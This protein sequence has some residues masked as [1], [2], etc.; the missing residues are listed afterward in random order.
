MTEKPR[1]TLRKNSDETKV[2]GSFSGI[3]SRLK[4]EKNQFR[5]KFLFVGYLFDRLSKLGAT[6]YLVGGEAVEYLAAGQFS[7]GDIDITTSNRAA[8]IKLLRSLGFTKTGM[9]WLNSDLKIAVQIV[10]SYPSSVEKARTISID[11]YKVSVVGVEDLIVDRLV[12]A[13][14]WRSN[15]KLDLEQASALLNEFRSGLDR[16]YLERRAIEEKVG[17]YLHSLPKLRSSVGRVGKPNEKLEGLPE[18]MF[19]SHPKMKRFTNSDES[20][21][22]KLRG[23]LD[24]KDLANISKSSKK[25]R[26]EFRL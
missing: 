2:A 6:A 18:S 4:K 11:G 25:F 7:T 14:Y 3:L 1:K 8:T 15:P 5:R 17:D 19:G 21:A 16:E 13:K 26:K 20:D 12:A 23:L 10:A 24:D 9:I 22:H